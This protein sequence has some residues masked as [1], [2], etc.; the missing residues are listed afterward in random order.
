MDNSRDARGVSVLN[1]ATLNKGTTF[2][3]TQRERLGLR[4]LLPP[5]LEKVETQVKR[6]W[7]QLKTFDEDLNK[8]IFLEN[9]HMQN[10]RLFYRV[11][12]ASPCGHS[13]QY[14]HGRDDERLLEPVRRI[15][16]SHR[17]IRR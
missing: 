6:A 7:E 9:L 16:R 4:G 8:Y 13:A 2:T 1:S 10:E 3:F 14:R 5:K 15:S 11:L 12:F 17:R